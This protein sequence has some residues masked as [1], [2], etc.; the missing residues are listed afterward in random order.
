MEGGVGRIG[1]NLYTAVIVKVPCSDCLH[2]TDFCDF[3][4][5]PFVGRSRV[6]MPAQRLPKPAARDE[7]HA[8]V[9][10]DVQ[11]DG[12]KVI[13]ILAECR[14]VPQP[15]PFAEDGLFV[16]VIQVVKVTGNQIRLPVVVYVD[17]AYRFE[18]FSR[19]KIGGERYAAFLLGRRPSG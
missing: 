15:M 17:Y 19:Y 13:K 5:G 8:P 7:V 14:L 18:T 9:L 12:R 1:Y 10:I 3:V 11:S 6:F 4:C 16:A 2:I